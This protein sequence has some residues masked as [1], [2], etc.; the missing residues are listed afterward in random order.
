MRRMITTSAL[1]I[2]MG[3]GA[4][5]TTPA[6]AGNTDTTVPINECVD[7]SA[8]C[9][10]NATCTDTADGYTCTCDSGFAGDAQGCETVCGDGLVKGDEAC[11]DS[12][13]AA[14]DG[15]RADCL[16]TEE[17]GD[18]MLDTAAGEQCDDGN[19]VAGDGCDDRCENE[20]VEGPC[21]DGVLNIG[22][23][24]DDGNAANG[25]GCEGCV[26]TLSDAWTCDPALFNAGDGC[27]CGC[28]QVDADCADAT[29]ESCDYCGGQGACNP[30]DPT[31]QQL[32][33]DDNSSCI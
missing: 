22:E 15:C 11:D 21:G 6:D 13:T 30:N 33:L 28:G 7:G 26:V 10:A 8:V 1:M 2:V 9:P 18:S 20:P 32:N 31:C 29:V 19:I 23:E 17:C 4:S 3:C 24:C 5:S 12:N 27:E 16:G 14:G 25:D